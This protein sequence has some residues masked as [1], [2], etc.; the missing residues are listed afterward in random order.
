MKLENLRLIEFGFFNAGLIL[1]FLY[2]FQLFPLI[3]PFNSLINVFLIL[4]Y[5]LLLVVFLFDYC[6][7]LLR[8]DYSRTPLEFLI[9]SFVLI[10]IL[11][12][13]YTILNASGQI[14]LVYFLI[15]LIFAL[16][17]IKYNIAVK[18][19]KDKKLL[20]Y[21]THKRKLDILGALSFALFIGVSSFTSLFDLTFIVIGILEIGGFMIY[22]SVKRKFF[23]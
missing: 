22:S 17:I 2:L 12:I 3:F 1:G 4:L 21:A 8:I 18:R 7:F 11:S 19:L 16:S 23:V 6:Y 14:S 15:L 5:F 10:F 9:D 20:H 13:P